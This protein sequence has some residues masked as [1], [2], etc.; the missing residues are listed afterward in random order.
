MFQVFFA[1]FASSFIVFFARRPDMEWVNESE[2][3]SEQTK[4]VGVCVRACIIIDIVQD[5]FLYS[6]LNRFKLAQS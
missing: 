1:V 5:T 2:R 3:A 6:A 4:C